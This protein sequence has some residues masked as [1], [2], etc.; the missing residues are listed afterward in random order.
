M[1]KFIFILMLSLGLVACQAAPSKSANP[2]TSPPASTQNT[3]AQ[4]TATAIP[5]STPAA[6]SLSATLNEVTGNVEAKDPNEANFSSAENGRTIQQEGQVRTLEDGYTRVDL[7][8]GTLIRMAPSSSFTLVENQPEDATLFTRIKLEFGQIWVILNGGSLEVETPSGQAAVRGSYMMVE[9]DPETQD[10][11][12]TC[13]EGQCTLENPAGMV[14]L[15]NGQRA[16]LDLPEAGE[17]FHIPSISEMSERDFAE[18]LFFAP[19]AEEIFPLLEEE[20]LVPWDEWEEIIPERDENLDF[21]DLL[22]QFPDEPLPDGELLPDDGLLPG[23]GEFI[24][25]D[26]LL[27]N[28][29]ALLPGDGDLLPGDGDLTPGDGDLTPGDGDLLPGDGDLTPG[30]GDLLPGDGDL[31]PNGDDPILPGRH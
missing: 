24:P 25:D 31:R 2:P 16:K 4:P 10:A 27:P 5:C 23:D 20:G 6:A 28:D 18:W 17:D 12:I 22:D 8:T 14:D 3:T 26:G 11:I 30:D 21:F 19:E 29:G 9:I 1:K 13:L 15:R 7:S